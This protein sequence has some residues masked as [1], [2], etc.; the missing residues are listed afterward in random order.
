M[1]FIVLITAV[2]RCLVQV[3]KKKDQKKKKEK[4]EHLSSANLVATLS[5]RNALKISSQS[6]NRVHFMCVWYVIG[7]IM[8]EMSS[9]LKVENIVM[10]S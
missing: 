5:T 6:S 3:F 9:F 8:M 2:F 10:I 1:C 4:E 7:V